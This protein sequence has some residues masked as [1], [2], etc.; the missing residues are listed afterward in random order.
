[1]RMQIMLRKSCHRTL[2]NSKITA[3]GP[4]IPHPLGWG[5]RPQF[6]LYSGI[7]LTEALSIFAIEK[8]QYFLFISRNYRKEKRNISNFSDSCCVTN[9]NSLYALTKYIKRSLLL[10]DSDKNYK[11]NPNRKAIREIP[12]C[13]AFPNG[14]KL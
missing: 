2:N 14:G 1:L 3:G 12:R 9:R 13:N 8:M 11:Y 6:D 10:I 7:I 4:C 5:G